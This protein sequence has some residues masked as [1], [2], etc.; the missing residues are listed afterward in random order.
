MNYYEID[1]NMMSIYWQTSACYYLFSFFSLRY[2]LRMNLNYFLFIPLILACSIADKQFQV[3]E[4]ILE[5]Y[6][7]A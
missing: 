3:I 2:F 1:Q 6:L 7:Y 5:L 4:L